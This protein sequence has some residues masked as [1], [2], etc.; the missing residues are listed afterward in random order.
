[1]VDD[2]G[3]ELY[4]R[5]QANIVAEKERLHS[6]RVKAHEPVGQQI[7][8]DTGQKIK[9]A[10][11]LADLLRR[12]KFHYAQLEHYGLG[13]P[14]LMRAEKE[15]AEIDIKYSGYIQR[16]KKQIEQVAKQTNRKLS[17]DIDYLAI[18]T[19]SMEAREKLTAVKPLTVGQAT[20]IGGVNPADIN[21]LLVH[22][23]IKDRQREAVAP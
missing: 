15:G 14:D 9:D 20:R 21:A 23:E 16:Q 6:T 2:R 1:M 17:Q 12:P 7:M 19:L 4:T 10:I 5:K 13:N 8:T 22:L 11:A 18:D 3:W